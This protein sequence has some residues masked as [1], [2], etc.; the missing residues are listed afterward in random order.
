MTIGS[1]KILDT[2]L[3]AAVNVRS[4]TL[5]PEITKTSAALFSAYGGAQ[6]TL[7]DLPYDYDALERKFEL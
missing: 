1:K 4:A 5:P 6:H 7:P 3:R 2:A